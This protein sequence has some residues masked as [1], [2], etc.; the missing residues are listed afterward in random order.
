MLALLALTG[1]LLSAC[2]AQSE[3]TPTPTTAFASEEEAFAAAEE[4]YR[5]YN[6]AYNA[7]DYS[8]AATFESL[9]D[10][11]SGVYR[12]EEREGLSELGA[13]GAVRSGNAV[14]V[15][16]DGIEFAPESTIRAR[17]CK[18]MS[19]VVVHDRDG[20]SMVSP[21]RPDYSALDLT[22]KSEDSALRLVDSKAVKDEK[23]AES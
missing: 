2:S 13:E 8:D 9:E 6:D 15:W 19:E 3:P 17:V 21:D 20:N 11:T 18:N 14:V 4:V 10:Y 5:E 12:T 1:A 7:V 16:F 22:F 23:C